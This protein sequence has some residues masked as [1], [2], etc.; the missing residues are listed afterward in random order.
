M[1]R[2]IGDVLVRTY[3]GDIT[4]LAVDAIAN[5][6][7]SDLWM[8]SGVAGAIKAKGG[9]EIEEEAIALGP[10]RPGESVMTTGGKLPAKYVLHCAGMPP[11]G[12]ATQWKVI[13]SVQSALT[14]ASQHNLKSIA[15]PAIGAGVGGLSEYD[16]AKAIVTGVCHYAR[17]PQSVKEITLVGLTKYVCE[18]FRK[19]IDEREE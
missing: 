13:S 15:F 19:A 2:K 7:N 16:S 1:E 6:A 17:S 11:G 14:I 9:I 5:A 12:K 3:L 8:G 18:C 4:E 10:I